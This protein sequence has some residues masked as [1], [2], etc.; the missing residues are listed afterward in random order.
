M[1][2]GIALA[3][4][5]PQSVKDLSVSL[6]EFGK[7]PII[8]KAVNAQNA[9]RKSLSSIQEMDAK[10]KSTP[11]VVG[12]MKELMESECGRY[13]VTLRDTQQYFTEIFAMDNQGANVC[14]SDKTSDYW[15]GDEAKFKNSY[16]GGK[17][18]V[19]VDEVEFDDSSQAYT[20]Q[21]SIPVLDGEKVI[22]AITF[23]ID[24]EYVQ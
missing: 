5:A 7:D 8:V 20:S 22:G 10:W 1:T 6:A 21:I 11:G 12:F 3:E 4:E 15:Q 14:L 2:G 16:N 13:L 17:G 9:Q 19:F 24:V 23:G 18:S